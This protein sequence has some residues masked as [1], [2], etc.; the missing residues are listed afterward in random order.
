VCAF[1]SVR[2]RRHRPLCAAQRGGAAARRRGGGI[3][4]AG[5]AATGCP[6]VS[7]ITMP[8]TGLR[9]RL[10]GTTPRRLALLARGPRAARQSA[11]A[12]RASEGSGRILRAC[13]TGWALRIRRPCWARPERR[14]GWLFKRRGAT[15]GSH[16]VDAL[17]GG[18]RFGR[19]GRI[20]PSAAQAGRNLSLLFL[21]NGRRA[22]V[23]G[24]SRQLTRGVGDRRYN[25]RRSRGSN[26]R[27][28]CG[29]PH[30]SRCAAGAHR[31]HRTGRLATASTFCWTT[32]VRPFSRS[33]RARRR[34]WTCTTRIGPTGCSMHT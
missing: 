30:P 28:G 17:V 18:L 21:A 24:I 10:R 8:R 29:V 22:E 32:I 12:G 23:I 31:A 14:R 34:R 16:V 11:R 9:G 1:G 13:W 7:T 5:P 3:R 4:S 19:A 20:F 6:A 26:R 33:T 2:R 27:S 15:G 25:L